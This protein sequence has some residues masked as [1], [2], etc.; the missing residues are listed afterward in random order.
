MS[1]KKKSDSSKEEFG[2]IGITTGSSGQHL[3]TTGANALGTSG[4]SGDMG[5]E[6]SKIDRST[7]GIGPSGTTTA[8]SPTVATDNGTR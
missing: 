4:A 6:K 1:D 8:T 7:D 2:I 3:S 5:N